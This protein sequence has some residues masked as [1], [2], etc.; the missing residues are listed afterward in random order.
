MTNEEKL[1]YYHK[2]INV[3]E[4]NLIVAREDGNIAL[5]FQWEAEKE[6]LQFAIK[7]LESIINEE[8]PLPP[9]E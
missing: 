2:Q 1:W 7:W 4:N 9:T 3:V 5:I 6:K 8:N